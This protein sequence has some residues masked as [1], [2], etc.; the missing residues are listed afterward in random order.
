MNNCNHFPL[1]GLLAPPYPIAVNVNKVANVIRMYLSILAVSVP[2]H[3]SYI[4]IN[5]I[6]FSG[7]KIKT[8]LR[9]TCSSQ[10]VIFFTDIILTST[11]IKSSIAF[12]H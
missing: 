2:I 4:Y 12:R 9:F 10:F 3:L 5:K 6:L 8:L 11:A 1:K 7:V